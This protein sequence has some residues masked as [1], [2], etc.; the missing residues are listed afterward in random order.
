M[1]EQGTRT[2]ERALTLLAIVCDRGLVGLAEAARLAE[3][4]PSTALRLLRTLE[5][6][7]F[8]RK[9][10]EGNYRPGSRVLQIG[11]QALSQESLVEISRDMMNHLVDQ[12]G[13]SVYLSV[14]RHDSTALY[15]NIHE[16]THSVRHTSW[17][18]RTFE[19]KS[20]AA[21][22]VL[23]GQTPAEGFITV[24]RGIEPDVTAI[25]APIECEGHLV[26]ALSL[27]IPSYRVSELQAVQYGR[28]LK[29][30]AHRISGAL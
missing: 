18:G 24:E 3:L 2:V 29:Q 12:T 23:L 1:S 26:A 19:M 21:G 27:V 4:P 6:A 10:Q 13:E 7:G 15:I 5:T 8:V 28:L 25:A 16:G 22:R 20:S 11:A 9:D 17:V 14:P 30:A